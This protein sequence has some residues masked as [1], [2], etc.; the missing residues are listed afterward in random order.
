MG[1]LKA[2]ATPRSIS[3]SLCVSLYHI[4]STTTS[5]QHHITVYGAG[6]VVTISVTLEKDAGLCG[7]CITHLLRVLTAQS[8]S[9]MMH[10]VNEFNLPNFN[11]K[12][13]VLPRAKS[14]SPM[15]IDTDSS[16]R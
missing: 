6:G 14:S 12:P 4:H 9:P 8:A 13:P 2:L 1:L 16:V 3:T 10:V 15:K 7:R 11:C 5:I